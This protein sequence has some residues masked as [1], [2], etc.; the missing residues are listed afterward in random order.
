MRRIKHQDVMLF[1]M[2]LLQGAQGARPFAAD[3]Q[4][5][6]FAGAAPQGALIEP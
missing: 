6:A 4:H 2:A 3:R 5:S 1:W